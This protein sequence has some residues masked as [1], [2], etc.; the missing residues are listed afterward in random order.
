MSFR[1]RIATLDDLPTIV[2]IYNSTIASREVTA[3]TEPVSVDSRLHWFHDH[4][5]ERRPLWVVERADD[6][7]ARPEILGW[8]SY[9]NFYGRPAYS[10][11]AE[12]SIYIAEA[13]RGKGIGKYA[14]TEAIAFAPQ[15]SVH[16]VLGF[17]FGHNGASLALFRKFGFEEWA[18]F[19]RVANLD[20][21]ERDLIILGKR[22]A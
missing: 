5:P 1:H 21:V 14:L 15:I 12:V 2:A 20:G 18:H 7:S 16:T 3:D 10:G 11:T 8:I 22:V 6:T 17:I 19:P 4:Q 13:W 9:S